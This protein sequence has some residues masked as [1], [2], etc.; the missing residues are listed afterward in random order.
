MPVICCKTIK[1]QKQKGEKNKQERGKKHHI[2]IIT[3]HI[4]SAIT[5]II[6]LYVLLPHQREKRLETREMCRRVQ[7]TTGDIVTSRF[8]L[9]GTGSRPLP[10]P[11]LSPRVVRVRSTCLQAKITGF[12]PLPRGTIMLVLLVGLSLAR[13]KTS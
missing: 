10:S 9:V 12:S 2:E 13:Q 7:R 6:L 5:I 8:H 11:P 1:K 4:W 3:L